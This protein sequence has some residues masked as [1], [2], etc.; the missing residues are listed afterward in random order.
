MAKPSKIGHAGGNS[1]SSEA[2][3]TQQLSSWF[4]R[5]WFCGLLLVLAVILAYEA[6]WRA[7]FIWMTKF[8]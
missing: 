8:M 1:I 5:D 4:S 2:A 6:V 7:G 3:F